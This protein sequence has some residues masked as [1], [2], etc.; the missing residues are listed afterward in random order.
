MKI[1]K[2]LT[3]IVLFTVLISG[4]ISSSKKPDSHEPEL[5]QQHIAKGESL[6]RE[7]LFSS[8]LEQYKLALTI[9]PENREAVRHKKEILSKLWEKAQL[10]YKKGVRFDEQGKYES[11]RKEYLS[12]LQ[13]WPDYKE[14]KERLTPGGVFDESKDYIIH[15][16]L[17][18]ES[19]SQL[20]MIY[21]GDFKKHSI[22]GRFNILKDV[23][24]VRVGE[25][26]KIPVIESVTLLS[27]QQKQKNYLNSQKTK[28]SV[29]A[30]SEPEKEIETATIETSAEPE[31]I[32]QPADEITEP[33]QDPVEETVQET[34]VSSEETEQETITP[35]EKTEQETIPPSEETEQETIPPS[36]ET[37]QE[38]IPPSEETEQET[39]PPSEETEQEVIPPSLEKKVP[40]HFVQGTKLFNQKKYPEAIPLFLAAKEV[41]PDDESLSDYLSKSHFQH[42]LTLYNSED[43]LSAK[44]NF[45]SAFKYDKN[46]EK[47]PNYIE[48]CLT[49]YKEKHYNLGIHY[50]GKEQLN[51][52]IEEWKMVK[53]IDPDYKDV[54]PNLKK[55]EM[56]FKRLESIKQSTSE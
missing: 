28:I 44:D 4:C 33:R 36:E 12:A 23:T 41:D 56:L 16:L 38:T 35:S 6:E 1:Y 40:D 30:V 2:I 18:G 26:L 45:E 52:A 54:T 8:A 21:Y 19:V 9:D 34:V 37:E 39:I 13:N 55:A 42:A 47:C 43:Y 49:T 7:S 53:K 20:A 11:A 14:A 48:K 15:T 24:K 31:T 22:I 17:Y 27:L 50:F 3:T 32:L 46:C 25:K 29:T 10:H 5:I 51:R